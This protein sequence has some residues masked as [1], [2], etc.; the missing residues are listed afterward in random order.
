MR[1]E[2][3]SFFS[4]GLRL[5]GDL[6]LPDDVR[7]GERRPT[8]VACSGYQGLKDMQPARFARAL[9]PRGYVCVAFDYRGFGRSE[10]PLGRL[11]PQ[12]QAEDVRAAVD[13]LETVPEADP[14][15]IVL[16]GWAL[17]G[18]VVVAE[19]AD[20]P[21]VSAVA[22]VNAIGS[23]ERSTRSMHDEQSWQCL[24]ARI[25]ADR[26]RRVVEGESELVTPFEIV[27]LDRVT[28]GYVSEELTRYPGFGTPVSLESAEL[29]LRFRPEDVVARL[30]SR[31]L[32]IVHGAEND[33]HPPSEAVELH[34][35]AAG[36]KELVLL[37][38]AGHTEWM[39]DDH[40]TFLRLV[41]TIE[42][43]LQAALEP[44]RRLAG[45]A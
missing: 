20:D 24:V 11:V 40:P 8:V 6:Y 23:G 26:R 42:R 18:G 30:A 35:L 9:V 15:R 19:A 28:H 7:P 27:R 1:R 43:F 36:P 17:G 4:R 12:E 33:L 31:P 29:L 37:E 5:D 16:L 41:G 13:F 22:V 21:R 45:A 34:R 25:A 14:E 32:L 39:Y 10:G 38:G 3:I 2:P 44:A